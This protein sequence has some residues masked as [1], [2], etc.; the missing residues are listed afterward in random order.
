MLENV[1]KLVDK[2][3]VL[4]F[5]IKCYLFKVFCDKYMENRL[6]IWN[7]KDLKINFNI[8]RQSRCR[9]ENKNEDE[10]LRKLSQQKG[11]KSE[12]KGD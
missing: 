12:K 9:N 5:K 8:S 2:V 3:L 4:C 6:E 10:D 1:V 11:I 7:L